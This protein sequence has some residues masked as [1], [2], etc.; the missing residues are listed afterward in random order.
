VTR[1]QPVPYVD[2]L[3]AE[4]EEI[5]RAFV[6]VL[7][8][9][10]I[11]SRNLPDFVITSVLLAWAPSD[12]A[13]QTDRMS[14]L[15]KVRDFRTRFEL[16]FPHPTPDVRERH[17]EALELLE[18][19]LDRGDGDSSLPPTIEAAV[20]IANASVDVLAAAKGLLPADEFD[21]RLVVDTNVLLDDPDLAQ[22]IAQLGNRYMAHVLPVVLREI[23]DHKRGGRT[24][25]LREA[26]KKADRRLKGLRDNGDVSVGAKVAGDVWAVFEH[27]EPRA[28]GLPSWLELDVPDDR[29]IA[30]T[31]LL[32]SRHPGSMLVAAT[33][34]LNLQT[35]L[36][37]VRLP[38]IEP[39]S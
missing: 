20:A 23:D 7:E 15:G 12:G 5:R 16:L 36:A 31:L 3:L 6:D 22:F 4:L 13:L 8:R 21:T 10:Q 9:S 29:F 30:S 28:E 27:V 26:A 18:R 37:A 2:Q 32:Q 11:K 19:W 17:D 35:K 38:F 34:D 33:S 39:A 24:E 25:T 1:Q 14:L